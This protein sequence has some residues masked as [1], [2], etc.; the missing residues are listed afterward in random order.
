MTLDP[1]LASVVVAGLGQLGLPLAVALRA[2]GY[3][4]TGLD[5]AEERRHE[6]LR[7]GLSVAAPSA[8][9]DLWP[10]TDMLMSVLPSD[11]AVM[12][13]LEGA[14]NVIHRLRKGAV[15]LCLGT[16]G[17]ELARDLS[18]RHAHAGQHFA[19]CP[20]FGRPDEAWARDLTAVFGPVRS[21]DCD[22]HT[23]AL[24]ALGA[25]APR[26]HPVPSPEAACAIKLA[27]NLMIASAITTMSEAT[28]LVRAYGASAES[29]HRVVTGKLFR[30][31]V[32]EGVGARLARAADLGAM[33]C[34]APGFTVRLGLKDMTLVHTAA[35]RA[36]V[37]LA[38]GAAVR[39]TLGQAQ[40]RGHGSADWADLPA[41]LSER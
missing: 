41:C 13:L 9:S 18:Q 22:W 17:I 36:G 24:Q 12:S 38:V 6:A 3:S 39:A 35:E 30:G 11:D 2:A 32:Y 19:S 15:H 28:R 4:V 16:I 29:L 10:R 23:V 34:E 5:V 21:E 40:Q 27:G 33:S 8:M 1:R 37:P 14:E 25:F 7:H 20:V 31:P 26:L